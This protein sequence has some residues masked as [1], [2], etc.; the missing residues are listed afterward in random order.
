M[1]HANHSEHLCETEAHDEKRPHFC[2]ALEPSQKHIR[3]EN[4][5]C[6]L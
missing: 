2:V 3:M 5:L 4:L 6:V 1:K